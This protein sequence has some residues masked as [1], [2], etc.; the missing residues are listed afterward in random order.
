MYGTVVLQGR[1]DFTSDP[2]S[3]VTIKDGAN[4]L[5]FADE[6]KKPKIS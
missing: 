3:Y 1:D 4:F 2:G 5:S 6:I